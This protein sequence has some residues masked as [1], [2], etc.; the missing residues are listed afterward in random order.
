MQSVSEMKWRGIGGGK[1]R[2]I[3]LQEAVVPGRCLPSTRTLRSEKRSHATPS[4]VQLLLITFILSSLDYQRTSYRSTICIVDKQRKK[5]NR[6]MQSSA[7]P[8]AANHTARIFNFYTFYGAHRPTEK[9][10]YRFRTMVTLQKVLTL[11]T[12][13]VPKSHS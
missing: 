8:C 5:I 13:A 7:A 4:L 6:S 1:G 10:A 2:S 12:R 3:P 9:F 11:H